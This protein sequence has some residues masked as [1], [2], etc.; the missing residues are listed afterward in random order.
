VAPPLGEIP[1]FSCLYPRPGSYY[2][3]LMRR[4][5][6]PSSQNYVMYIP[7]LAARHLFLPAQNPPPPSRL[8]NHLVV[9]LSPR[10]TP[11]TLF[12][13]CKTDIGRIAI[14]PFT[15]P[16]FPNPPKK[17]FFSLFLFRLS[18]FLSCFPF[19]RSPDGFLH[20]DTPDIRSL[21]YTSCL[22]GIRSVIVH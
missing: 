9:Q 11:R 22:G 3:T 8:T 21:M 12:V 19:R 14:T 10:K 4:A 15:T 7:S 20:G 13:E 17:F 2:Q 16:H 18:G 5:L 6:P 1:F